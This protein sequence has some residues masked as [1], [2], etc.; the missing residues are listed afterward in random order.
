MLSSVA[1]EVTVRMVLLAPSRF[2]Y[3]MGEGRGHWQGRQNSRRS[4]GNETIPSAMSASGPLRG[5][6]LTHISDT[7]CSGYD[8]AAKSLA[9]IFGWITGLGPGACRMAQAHCTFMNKTYGY[10]LKR[11][12]PRFQQFKRSY[13]AKI[14]FCSLTPFFRYT[15]HTA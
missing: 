6:S 13:F 11:P 1:A 5:A 14:V 15:F 2:M 10:S 9:F 8:T 3:L 4:A 12:L 7:T